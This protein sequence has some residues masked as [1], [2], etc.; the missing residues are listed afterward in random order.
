MKSLD[1]LVVGLGK[2][3]SPTAVNGKDTIL[4]HEQGLK[5]KLLLI[6]FSLHQQIN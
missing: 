6:F 5:V 1:M 4:S 3:F 2:E